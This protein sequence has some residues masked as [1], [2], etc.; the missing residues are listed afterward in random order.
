[1]SEPLLAVLRAK[2]RQLHERLLRVI[3]DLD[4]AQ[5][6]WRPTPAAHSM[7]FTLWHTARADDNVQADLGGGEL[8]WT[9][10]RYAARWGHPERGVG[11]GWDDE[12]AAALPLPPKPQLIEYAREVFAAVDAAVDRLEADRFA[13]QI[14]SRF[15]SGPSTP[16]EIVLVCIGHGNRHLGEMEYIKGLQGLRGSVTT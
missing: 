11:T 12:R 5:I 7:G 16:G 6:A 2:S 10:G 1:M 14:D 8:L 15:M 3:E 9:R 13:K 4:D